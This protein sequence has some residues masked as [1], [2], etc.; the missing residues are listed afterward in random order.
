MVYFYQFIRVEITMADSKVADEVS[1]RS[2][3][4]LLTVGCL[5]AICI[6]AS[7][8]RIRISDVFGYGCDVVDVSI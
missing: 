7:S 3:P 6:L 4:G 5:A 1:K 8:V 2:L